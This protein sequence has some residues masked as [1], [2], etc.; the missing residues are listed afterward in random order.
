M[1]EVANQPMVKNGVDLEEL[2]KNLLIAVGEDP[3][4]EGLGR[5]PRRVARSLEFLTEGYRKSIKELLSGAVFEEKYNEMVIVKD[6]DFYS[7]CEH[8]L[9][10]FY[11]K[12]HIAYIPNGKI[13]GLSKIPRIVEVYSR[14]LQVQ[15]RFTQQV[16]DTL[17]DL[18]NPAGVAV[19]AEAHH[20][21]MMMRGVEKQNSV[22]TTSAML[23]VFRED[24]RT[25]EEFLNLITSKLS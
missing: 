9:L 4:R 19:V 1:E 11:G 8:H 5:T 24:L 12:C 2:V 21:C 22:A 20:L 16:A 10:P 25:R 14:R 3:N 13:L 7:M 23:G 15:E 6:I 18:L 17:Y